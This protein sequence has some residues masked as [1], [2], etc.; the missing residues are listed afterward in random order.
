MDKTLVNEEA[1]YDDVMFRNGLSRQ[2]LQL[3]EECAEL[4]KAASKAFR[5]YD[6]IPLNL[7]DENEKKIARQFALVVRDLAEEIADVEIMISQLKRFYRISEEDIQAYKELKLM[8]L[9]ERMGVKK[10]GDG[11]PPTEKEEAIT[12]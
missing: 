11:L 7:D 9:I 8:R 3:A 12:T 5:F 2:T 4:V 1:L 10:G 6:K